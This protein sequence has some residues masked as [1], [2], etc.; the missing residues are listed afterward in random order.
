MWFCGL[1]GSGK[2]TLA[3]TVASK[4]DLPPRDLVLISMDAIR[5][6]IFPSP[7]YTEEERDAAYRAFVLA[8]SLISNLGSNVILDGTGHK[9]IWRDTAR[10][11]CSRFVEIYVKCPIEICMQR[12]TARIDQNGIRKRLY[13]DAMERL[14]SGRSFA[15]LGNVPGVDEPFEEDPLSEIVVD[16]TEGTV[17][18]QANQVLSELRRLGYFLGR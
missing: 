15:G 6:K 9:K 7:R 12:E 14:K 17:E 5:K 3:R 16:S 10:S 18:S 13:M 11:D 8:A 4:L 1:P 2:S